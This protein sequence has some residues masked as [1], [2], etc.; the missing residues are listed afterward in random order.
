MKFLEKR[1]PPIVIL[2]GCGAGMWVLSGKALDWPHSF[3]PAALFFSF[4]AIGAFFCVSGL[5]SFK[6][7]RTTVN[8]MT[9]EKASALVDSGMYRVSRNPMYVGFGFFLLAWSVYLESLLTVIGIVVFVLY[10]N[11]FQ[12]KPEERAL[13]QLFGEEFTHYCASVRRW[14]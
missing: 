5:V 14:L 7:A 8:P 12:I 2:V 9:P 11:R 13:K 6:L 4:F 10:M 1:V 3:L